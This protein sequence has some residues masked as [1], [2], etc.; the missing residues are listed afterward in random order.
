[1]RKW[2]RSWV[3]Y[4]IEADLVALQVGKIRKETSGCLR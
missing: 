2:P 4:T 3:I 1:M